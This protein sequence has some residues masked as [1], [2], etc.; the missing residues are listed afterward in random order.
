MVP[1]S[2]LDGQAAMPFGLLA[3]LQRLAGSQ[4]LIIAIWICALSGNSDRVSRKI[5]NLMSARYELVK[6]LV[7]KVQDTCTIDNGYAPEACSGFS[8][9]HASVTE[10][11][12]LTRLATY[13]LHMSGVILYSTRCRRIAQHDFDLKSNETN[14][15]PM[16]V[17]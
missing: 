12:L 2:L 11:C 13:R 8:D 16:E 4:T 9:V 3:I 14:V 15:L 7:S 17:A 6:S 1:N 10:L 5:Q